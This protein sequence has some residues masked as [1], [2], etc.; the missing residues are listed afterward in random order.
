MQEHWDGL[1]ASQPRGWRVDRT[2]RHPPHC[3]FSLFLSFFRLLSVI[4]A[5]SCDSLYLRARPRVPRARRR[6][7]HHCT[8]MQATFNLSQDIDQLCMQDQRAKS[9]KCVIGERRVQNRAMR[10]LRANSDRVNPREASRGDAPRV[11]GR[12]Q[13]SRRFSAIQQRARRRDRRSECERGF[14]RAYM[15]W[16]CST[17]G[18]KKCEREHLAPR[19]GIAMRALRGVRVCVRVCAAD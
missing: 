7:A 8:L 4:T 16:L 15:F 18:Q 12:H 3:V 2:R 9:C 10:A 19:W 1:G 6:L 5:T 14:E 13:S 17:Q 11:K